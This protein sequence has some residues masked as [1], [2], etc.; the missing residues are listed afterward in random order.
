[1]REYV[2]IYLF[3]VFFKAA[4]AKEIVLKRFLLLVL[5]FVYRL[6]IKL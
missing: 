5:I 1:M 4:H 6:E 3:R 2:H